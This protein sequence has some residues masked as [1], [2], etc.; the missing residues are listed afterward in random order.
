MAPMVYTF[1]ESTTGVARGPAGYPMLY[2]TGY[3]CFQSSF[4]VSAFRH[5]MRSFASRRRPIRSVM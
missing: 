2:S 4:P 5:W 3:S 1:P